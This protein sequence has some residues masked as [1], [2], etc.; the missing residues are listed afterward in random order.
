MSEINQI[1][2]KACSSLNLFLKGNLLIGVPGGSDGP[3]G[4]IV[5]CE[6]YLV[7]KNLGD[8]PDVRC[9]IPRRRVIFKKIFLLISF[10]LHIK[11]ITQFF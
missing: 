7:Y 8:Q 10:H 6:N 2:L 3:S 9:P 11:N 1:M 4:V 5:C